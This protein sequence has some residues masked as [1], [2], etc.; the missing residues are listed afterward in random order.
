MT[1]AFLGWGAENIKNMNGE[2]FLSCNPI[3]KHYFPKNMCLLPFL[4]AYG[5]GGLFIWWLWK[6]YP[7]ISWIAR[8]ILFIIGFN[9]IE[10]IAGIIGEKII[11]KKINTCQKGSKMWNYDGPTSFMGY[12]DLK[13]TFLWVL[14]GIPGYVLWPSLEK[15]SLYTMLPYALIIWLGIS[16]MKYQTMAKM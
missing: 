3:A 4:V 10:L 5:F 16:L 6:Y 1:Y 15:M 12:I 8:I 2:N 11:C 14:I 13:H 9:V 7:D